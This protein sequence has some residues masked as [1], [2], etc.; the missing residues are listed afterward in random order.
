MG[1]GEMLRLAN[2]LDELKGMADELMEL[3][4][5][6]GW[7]GEEKNEIASRMAWLI[8]YIG[9]GLDDVARAIRR[10]VS[11]FEKWFREMEQELEE[12]ESIAEV[13]LPHPMVYDDIS[14]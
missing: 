11:M 12:R 1:F 8:G 2:K 13:T 10:E 5:K 3:L 4:K 7:L 14:P 6:L 9:A